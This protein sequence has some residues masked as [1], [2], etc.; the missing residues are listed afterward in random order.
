MTEFTHEQIEA[1]MSKAL[2]EGN[3]EA[4]VG[5]LHVLAVQAPERAQTILDW[6]EIGKLAKQKASTE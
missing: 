3:M 5:M 6:I 4:V 2:A 1:G